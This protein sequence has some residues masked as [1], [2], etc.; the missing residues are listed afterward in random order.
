MPLPTPY[1]TLLDTLKASIAAARQRA[2]RQVNRELIGLYWEIGRRIVESQEAHG[3]GKSVVEDLARDLRVAFPDSRGFSPRN[4]WDM[5]KFYLSYKDFP[6]LQPL[7]AEIGWTLNRQLLATDM[8]VEKRE[9]YLR[10]VINDGWT[11]RTLQHHLKNQTYERQRLEPKQNNFS[12]HLPENLA[13]QANEIIKSSYNLEF[14]GLQGEVLESEL[15]ARLISRLQMFILELGYGFT[16]VGRQFRLT[17]NK[18]YFVDLL[19]YHRKLRCLVALELKTREFKPEYVG[20]LN[21]YLE[22]LDDQVRMPEENPSIGIL[23]VTKQDE[24]E[25]EYALRAAS[26][27][28]G[29]A[30][31]KLTDELPANLA[32]LL[33]TPQQLREQLHDI[34]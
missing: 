31:Y 26:R 25:V 8:T 3:W 17:L 32:G 28:V 15:E 7:A 1:N 5:R 21:F 27:P 30:E 6:N 14:L 19:F 24:L 11:R 23:L 18:D 10:S 2:I 9:F 29:V 13:K 33:P 34:R 4:L 20:K 16:F 12:N 22:I